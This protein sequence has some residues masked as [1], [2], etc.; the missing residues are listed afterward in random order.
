MTEQCWQTTASLSNKALLSYA[1]C[2]RQWYTSS[3]TCASC[4]DQTSADSIVCSRWHA[5]TSYVSDLIGK[6]GWD[7]EA[8]M[9][10]NPVTGSIGKASMNRHS[11]DSHYTLHCTVTVVTCSKRH[12]VHHTLNSQLSHKSHLRCRPLCS[13]PSRSSRI[14]LYILEM[15]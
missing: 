5:R 12:I 3:C 1:L 9:F 4:Q 7:S 8:C 2:Q 13:S 10:C 15:S 14:R 6:L 11:F